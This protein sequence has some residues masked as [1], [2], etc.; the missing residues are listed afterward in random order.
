MKTVCGLVVIVSFSIIIMLVFKI[1]GRENGAMKNGIE[2]EA[3]ILRCVGRSL[4]EMPKSFEGA[5]VF[6]GGFRDIGSRFNDPRFDVVVQSKPFSK[7]EFVSEVQRRIAEL[8]EKAGDT[9]DVFK[10]EKQIDEN[11]AIYRVQ[12][13]DDAYVSEI[14]ILVGKSLATVSL[15]S[16]KNQY[17]DAE[18]RLLKLSR[19]VKEFAGDVSKLTIQE[20]CLGPVIIDGDFST[21]NGKFLF[22]HGD[23]SD[24]QI[25][26]NTY[27][28]DEEKPLL[29][30]MSGPDSLLRIFDVNHKVLRSGE[31]NVANMHAQEWLGWAKLREQEDTKSLQFTLETMRPKPAK[32]TPKINVTYNSGNYLPGGEIAKA[33]I[34]DDHAI[35]LWDR[36]V[37]S[38]RPIPY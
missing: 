13:I 36:V 10:Y 27:A 4:I 1:S 22:K 24:F 15:N 18:N 5:S 32:T 34:S 8:K 21:E 14:K 23:D 20:F 35:E 11:T 37:N 38:I 26:I 6:M 7:T 19:R 3:M 16:H 17:I 9:V 29:T 28:A 31:R 30:R 25:D 33:T 2:P 12:E